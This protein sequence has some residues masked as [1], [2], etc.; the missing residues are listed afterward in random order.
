VNTTCNY[1]LKL[2]IS[3]KSQ[4]LVGNQKKKLQ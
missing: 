4:L 2:E 3:A 1:Y